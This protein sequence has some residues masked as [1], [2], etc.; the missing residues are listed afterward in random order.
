M[1]SPQKPRAFKSREFGIELLILNRRKQDEEI[2]VYGSPDRF[3]Y[4]AGRDG[5]PCGGSVPEDGDQRGYL[6]QLEEEVRRLR[7]WGAAASASA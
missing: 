4:Q 7:C 5:Y 2:E 1:T 6:L 3:C